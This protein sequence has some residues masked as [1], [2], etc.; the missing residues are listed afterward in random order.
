MNKK[1]CA[2]SLALQLKMNVKTLK[3]HLKNIFPNMI[4]EKNRTIF[5]SEY[6]VSEILKYFKTTREIKFSS[7]EE[8]KNDIKEL[9]KNIL[10]TNNKNILRNDIFEI[11]RLLMQ[12]ICKINELS[13]N[14]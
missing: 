5:F 12:L 14:M 6:E 3:K 1:I 13:K 9:N 7:F 8:T 11:Q 2:T 10:E 4:I